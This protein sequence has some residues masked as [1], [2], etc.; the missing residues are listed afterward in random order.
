MRPPSPIPSCLLQPAASGSGFASYVTSTALPLPPPSSGWVPPAVPLSSLTPSSDVAPFLFPLGCAAT[1]L[2]VPEYV[3][4]LRFQD[5]KGAVS[6]G[7][8]MVRSVERNG[9]EDSL[10]AA[11]RLKGAR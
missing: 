2:P 10:R 1:L 6:W 8:A 5:E 9:D 7:C 11:L 3:A 4:V